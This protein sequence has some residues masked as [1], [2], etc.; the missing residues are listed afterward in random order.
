M[1]IIKNSAQCFVLILHLL[2]LNNAI[3]EQDRADL[4]LDDDGLIEI[5]DIE[6]FL[7]VEV[8][9]GATSTLYGMSNGCPDDFCKGYELTRDID[10]SEGQDSPIVVYPKTLG[11]QIFEGN[12]HALRNFRLPSSDVAGLF[13][14]V[15]SSTIR[16]LTIDVADIPIHGAVR[17][18]GIT[19]E[20]HFSLILNCT[21]L[22]DISGQL[23]IGGLI[24][25][26]NRTMIINSHFD[27]VISG[28][29]IA[30]GL[31]GIAEK[32]TLY[33]SSVKGEIRSEGNG[34]YD[35]FG[36][37]GNDYGSRIVASLVAARLVGDPLEGFQG[38]SLVEA[39]YVVNTAN[40]ES[41]ATL[42]NGLHL[43][44]AESNGKIE[45][46]PDVLRCP[47]SSNNT[48][49]ADVGLFT[50]W[51]QYV[52]EEGEPI[53]DFGDD[54]T[55]PSIRKDAVFYGYDDDGDH[56]INLLDAF[57]LNAAASLDQDRDGKPEGWTGYCTETCQANSGLELDADDG[58]ILPLRIYPP[59]AQE[60]A[61]PSAPKAGALDALLFFLITIIFT[62]KSAAFSRNKGWRK[63]NY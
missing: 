51:D 50:N 58:P 8:S 25:I 6:D 44:T 39:S 37:I 16:N 12:G 17:V 40:L 9:W 57:P 46:S 15:Y 53:W 32:S 38:N 28:G 54:Q 23:E 20:A 13:E 36:M 52:D 14:R 55:L 60:D 63:R 18:G 33:A 10:F 2:I 43:G 62:Y 7:A 35:V 22:A 29:S 5:N 27:G 45:L 48:Q 1:R 31:I 4:D 49:C 26:A 41:S 11:S 56:V 42:V 21:V 47:T 30:G 34:N 3:A 24:G 59:E 61:N 19:S